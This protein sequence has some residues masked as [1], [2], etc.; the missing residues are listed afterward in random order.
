MRVC[1]EMTIEFHTLAL[2]PSEVAFVAKVM[3]FLHSL[4]TC[5]LSFFLRFFA[6]CSGLNNNRSDLQTSLLPD[7]LLQ[8]TLMLLPLV[9]FSL[10]SLLF[11][12]LVRFL[13]KDLLLLEPRCFSRSCLCRFPLS[14]FPKSSLLLFD[15]LVVE[16]KLFFRLLIEIL[17]LGKNDTSCFFSH[18]WLSRGV[19]FLALHL[20]MDGFLM[21]HL[22]SLHLAH[23]LVHKRILCLFESG[24]K[25]DLRVAVIGFPMAQFL[26]DHPLSFHSLQG[27]HILCLSPDENRES[28]KIAHS[29]LQLGQMLHKDLKLVLDFEEVIFGGVGEKLYHW[30][31]VGVQGV[32]AAEVCVSHGKLELNRSILTDLLCAA[33]VF[34]LRQV[35]LIGDDRFQG[36]LLSWIALNAAQ[37]FDFEGLYGLFALRVVELDLHLNFLSRGEP[38]LLK[39][40]YRPGL[41]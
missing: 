12:L 35:L 16:T 41:T 15:T 37:E 21:N 11:G 33:I 13:S 19:H 40:Y 4:G 31:Q 39:R 30:A 29:K 1:F 25:S 27:G 24:P 6:V 8:L 17:S 28:H 23:R 36:G 20:L 26:A 32:C 34:D 14:C 9:L 3:T 5:C 18:A 22:A 10:K 2:N 7:L 38:Q